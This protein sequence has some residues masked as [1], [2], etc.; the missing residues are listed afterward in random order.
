MKLT[1]T[2]GEDDS[3]PLPAVF[4]ASFNNFY[5]RDT[6]T[7]KYGVSFSAAPKN[8]IDSL[9]ESGSTD[10]SGIPACFITLYIASS[11]TANLMNQYV[12]TKASKYYEITVKAAHA[13]KGE[14][15]CD[16]TDGIATG[17][18]YE[19]AYTAVDD[20][21]AQKLDKLYTVES[22]PAEDWVHPIN[23]RTTFS[24]IRV[25]YT[26][27]GLCCAL[28]NGNTFVAL[29]DMGKDTIT[30]ACPQ[31]WDDIRNRNEIEIRSAM[32]RYPNMSVF[33]SHWHEDH[34][35]ILLAVSTEYSI[36]KKIGSIYEPFFNQAAL[37]APEFNSDAFIAKYFGHKRLYKDYSPQRGVRVRRLLKTTNFHLYKADRNGSTHPHDYGLFAVVQLQSGAI[38]LLPGDTRYDT[39]GEDNPNSDY[40][41]NAGNG[42]DYLVA[43]HHGGEYSRTQAIVRQPTR[44]DYIPAPRTANDAIIYS[45]NSHNG[46][47]HPNSDY[48]DEYTSKGWAGHR[49]E[50][51]PPGDE[52]WLFT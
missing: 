26:G 52:Y 48:V 34:I 5:P 4:Y 29:F 14:D 9:L 19:F 33:I 2:F 49:T 8:K 1:Y 21:V 16:I 42:Y 13:V 50:E 22:A 37:Y 51:L 38:A 40:L 43:S 31:S 25:Y 36:T 39:M 11:V 30:T 15:Y 17:E 45:A 28:M 3:F 20:I 47:G 44:S 10:L 35:N 32:E 24:E 41:D 27:Q 18:G 7:Q 23:N 12:N 46:Y 6:L